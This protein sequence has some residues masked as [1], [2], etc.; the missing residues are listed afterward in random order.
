MTTT[1]TP[2]TNT[3]TNH[4]TTMTIDDASDRWHHIQETFLRDTASE[5]AEESNREWSPRIND[6]FFTAFALRDA[7]KAQLPVKEVINTPTPMPEGVKTGGLSVSTV[8]PTNDQDQTPAAKSPPPPPTFTFTADASAKATPYTTTPHPIFAAAT[9]VGATP[10]NTSIFGSTAFSPMAALTPAAGSFSLNQ[11]QIP[12]PQGDHNDDDDDAGAM[13]P[14]PQEL[15]PKSN[16][17]DYQDLLEI[18]KVALLREDGTGIKATATGPLRV[19]K[20]ITDPKSHRMV[21][22]DAQAG[23]VRLNVAIVKEMPFSIQIS[24]DG[25]KGTILFVAKLDKDDVEMVR[26]KARIEN[27]NKLLSKLRSIAEVKHEETGTNEK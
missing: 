2:S 25:T 15:V 27:A 8:V 3:T 24:K 19:Q 1:N 6:L 16:D 17:A 12:T 22:R 23:H 13:P 14:E 21:M 20:S 9:P 7:Y 4:T 5:F 11:Q 26:I 18:D 10:S